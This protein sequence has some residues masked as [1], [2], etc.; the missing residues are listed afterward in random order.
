MTDF[1][2][3]AES[4]TLVYKGDPGVLTQAIPELRQV[5]G[6][7]FAVPRNLRN[8]QVLRYMNYPVTPIM[9]GYEW[10]RHPS[11][12]NPYESQMMA[13]N[14]M[15]L[16]RRCFNLSDLGSGKTLTML[17]AADWLMSQS[18]SPFKGLIVAPLS[19]LQ[20]VWADGI[21]KNFLSAR[22]YAIL[23]GDPA[24]RAR[25]LDR[26]VDFYIINFDGVGTGARTKKK[27]ELDGFSKAL[28]E[29]DDIRLAIVDE[30]SA[31]KDASTKR[32][33][34]ARQVF[35]KKEYLWL[36]TGT[37]TPNA[38]TDA[39][40]LAKLVN[41]AFGKSFGTF[42]AET[43]FK[44]HPNAF[45]W[46]PLKDGYDKAKRLLSP[47]V[48]IDIRDVWDAPEMTTQQREV[49]LTDEQKKLMAQLKRDLQVEMKSG[50]AINAA[51][52]AA[53]RQ[54]FMQVSMGA[55]YDEAH[56]VH[57]VDAAPRYR[58]LADVVEQAPSKILCFVPL[59]SVVNNVYKF[60]RDKKYTVEI[61]NGEVSQ[62]DRAR[63]FK[64][65]QESESP[66]IICA[67]PATASHGLD[68]FAAQTVIWF[69][70]TDKAEL[71]AQAN[72]RAH[73]PGQKY[74]VTVVQIVSNA[75]ER[76][77]FRRLENNLSLQGA[78]LDSVTKGD[79]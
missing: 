29:R 23:H 12:K 59:T 35:G 64:A 60:L 69:G 66:R 58:E 30:A 2:H 17:W 16:H 65:F 75:L 39:Y 70:A 47:A 76:E 6:A 41:N 36:L 14:F 8:L 15:V 33:R 72:K 4:N 38:P 32:H 55:V 71:F 68:L 28:A 79:F 53:A 61:V 1:F 62:K 11:I 27:F 51:N 63:I 31:Y 13:A 18:R 67:D 9:D 74:P 46:F 77:I 26:D 49:E 78:L 40:G 3:H 50:K 43:M 73:R 7:F 37:P 54:K 52:E 20:R 56:K 19:I 44:P 45:K 10:P 57:L 34:I 24:K 48:R 42:Q 21:V 25:E 22:S 5:N